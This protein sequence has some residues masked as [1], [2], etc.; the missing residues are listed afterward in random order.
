MQ[1]NQMAVEP[2]RVADGEAQH[3]GK[4]DRR[5]AE[6]HGQDKA[7]K[8]RMQNGVVEG[9]RRHSSVDQ[10][11]QTADRQPDITAEQADRHKAGLAARL[12]P[13]PGDV[14]AGQP[15]GQRQHSQPGQPH[16]RRVLSQGDEQPS[17]KKS[18]GGCKKTG[19]GGA[20]S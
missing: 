1:Q 18:G 5:V 2:G 11:Q 17:H 10:R 14:I 7:Q 15:D 3:R 8:E 19:C 13:S 9:T 6:N 4:D 20:E 16:A 12:Q